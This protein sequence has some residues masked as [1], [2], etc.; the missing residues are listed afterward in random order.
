MSKGTKI[1]QEVFDTIKLL[2]RS[3]I[4]SGV[5]AQITKRSKATVSRVKGCETLD[6]YNDKQHQSYLRFVE[7]KKSKEQVSDLFPVF[8]TNFSFGEVTTKFDTSLPH[9]AAETTNNVED[10]TEAL[11][12]KIDELITAIKE[13]KRRWL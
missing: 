9:T 7:Q 4:K 10:K 12:Q 11:I 8:G 13:S 6:E 1:T 2:Q 3:G 5:I